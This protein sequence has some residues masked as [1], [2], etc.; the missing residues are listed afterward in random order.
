MKSFPQVRRHH[1]GKFQ[2]F[3][4]MNAHQAHGLALPRRRFRLLLALLLRLRKT[5]KARQAFA[6][7]GI[8]LPGQLQQPIQVGAPLFP[9]PAGLEPVGVMR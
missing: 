6:A 8:E 5:E 4:L 2:P 1:H 9:A 3:A 7:A